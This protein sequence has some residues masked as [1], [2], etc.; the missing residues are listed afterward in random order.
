VVV[1][2]GAEYPAKYLGAH[3]GQTVFDLGANIGS[4]AVYFDGLNPG[5]KYRGFAFEPF[6]DNFGLLKSNIAA[7]KVQNFELIEAA[8]SDVDGMVRIDTAVSPD[9][10]SITDGQGTDVVSYKLSSFCRQHKIDQIDLLKMDIEGAEYAIFETDYEFLKQS[11]KVVILEYHVLSEK[12]NVDWI[13][14][15]TAGDFVSTTIHT[16]Q[17]NG[18]IVLENKR[19]GQYVKGAIL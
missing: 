7:N 9:A 17:M 6:K 1:M 15:R 16:N 2:S 3:D 5:V 14:E 12:L 19:L 8:V 4:F 13:M 10:V 11:V 18:V